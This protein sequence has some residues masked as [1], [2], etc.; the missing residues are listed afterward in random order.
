MERRHTYPIEIKAKV[1][2]NT[3]LLISEL[4]KKLHKNKSQIIRLILADFFNR[5]IELLDSNLSSTVDR[6][7]LLE[8]ILKDF[9]QSNKKEINEFNKYK[10]EK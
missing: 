7:V 10:N 8:T 2:L 5:N 1:D 4:S 3:D 9:M 6:Q